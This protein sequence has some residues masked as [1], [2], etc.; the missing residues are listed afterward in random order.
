MASITKRTKRGPVTKTKTHSGN[1]TKTTI[2]QGVTRHT[3]SGGKKN[4]SSGSIRTTTSHKMDSKSGH[5]VYQ[6]T[7]VRGPWG[8]RRIVKKL[9]EHK[10]PGRKKSNKPK[11]IKKITYRGRKATPR[12]VFWLFVIFII[13]IL[14]SG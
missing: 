8:Y 1:K 13:V 10:K 5:S 14:L 2:S 3:S 6:T 11:P 4:K 9:S 12:E 7:T